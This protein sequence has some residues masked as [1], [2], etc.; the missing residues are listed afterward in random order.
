MAN[1]NGQPKRMGVNVWVCLYVVYGEIYNLY[2]QCVI[3]CRI[4]HLMNWQ[5]VCLFHKCSS[6]FQMFCIVCVCRHFNPHFNRNVSYNLKF[7]MLFEQHC[8]KSLLFDKY[9]TVDF[10]QRYNFTFFLIWR[11]TVGC[12]SAKNT[13]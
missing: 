8:I 6:A 9:W 10:V 7:I 4:N 13:N 12:F 1:W 11:I 2:L 5:I 3:A